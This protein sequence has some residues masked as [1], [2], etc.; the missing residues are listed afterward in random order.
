MEKNIRRA[1]MKTLTE[2]QLSYVKGGNNPP[3]TASATGTGA[4]GNPPKDDS[5]S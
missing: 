5:D 3:P 1:D 2:N 4:P